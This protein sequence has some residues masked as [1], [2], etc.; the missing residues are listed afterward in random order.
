MV[1]IQTNTEIKDI[2]S[3]PRQAMQLHDLGQEIGGG[4]K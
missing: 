1:H 2:K 3:E 4:L